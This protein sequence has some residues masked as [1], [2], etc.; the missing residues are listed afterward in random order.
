MPQL[1]KVDKLI[2]VPCAKKKGGNLTN[3]HTKI[4]CQG[5]QVI[6]KYL[7]KIDVIIRPRRCLYIGITKIIP[8]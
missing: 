4:I 3:S 2:K 5:R 8:K 1:V 6:R 7:V